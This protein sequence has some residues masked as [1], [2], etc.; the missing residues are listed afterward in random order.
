MVIRSMG[1]LS[2]SFYGS[3]VRQAG[4][5]SHAPP[6]QL[7]GGVVQGCNCM[8]LTIKQ[9]GKHACIIMNVIGESLNEIKV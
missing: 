9:R 6:S 1:Q 2:S 4:W 3:R 8:Q 5:R 7:R